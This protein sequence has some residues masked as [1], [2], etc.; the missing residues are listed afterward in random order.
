MTQESLSTGTVKSTAQLGEKF[1]KWR[2]GMFLHFN[3]ATFNER[4][5]ACGYEDPAT[6]APDKLDCNQWADAAAAAGMK[7]AILTTKHTC[8]WCLWN[9]RHTT[10]DMKAFANYKNG[11]GDI[12]REF[13][14]AFRKRGLKIGLYYCFPGDFS[15][16]NLPPGKPDLHGLPPEAQGDYAGFIKKQLTELLTGYGAID[17][18]WIDQYNSGYSGDWLA[19]K[20]HIKKSL[21]PNCIVIAN[22]SHDFTE[23]DIYGYEYP[24]TKN[25]APEKALPPEGNTAPSEVC[26]TIG[27]GWFWSASEN[28]TNLKTPDA[29]ADMVKL[30]NSWRANYL[31]NVAPD[32]SGLIPPH[33]V[34]RLRKVGLLLGAGE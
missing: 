32:K 13:T 31:L 25:V 16:T 28:E 24:Y 7:Y 26:D 2:F 21:Q 18:V 11:K 30:C 20:A 3:L 33:S 19:F 10:H 12:V 27:P 34:E 5:W 29:I 14:E 1:L 4:E 9:S 8:G 22:N 15:G 17:L 6:F 23:T